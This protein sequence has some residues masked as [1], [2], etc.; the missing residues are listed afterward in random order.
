M[1]TTNGAA[2]T[3]TNYIQHEDHKTTSG[4]TMTNGEGKMVRNEVRPDDK[5]VMYTDQ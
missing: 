3:T 1:T 5:K 4:M 2:M